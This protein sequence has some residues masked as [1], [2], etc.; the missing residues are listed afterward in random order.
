MAKAKKKVEAEPVTS[1]KAEEVAINPA[2][3]AINSYANEAVQQTIVERND[4]TN[5]GTIE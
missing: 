1:A 2:T 3:E 4:Q 5:A